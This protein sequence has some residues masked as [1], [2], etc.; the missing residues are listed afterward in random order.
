MPMS[1]LSSKQLNKYGRY[2]GEPTEEQLAHHFYL[3][4][5]DIE[6]INAHR[7]PYS[8]LGFALQLCTLRFLGTFLSEPT[9][10]P[11]NVLAY[12]ARQLKIADLGCINKYLNRP[13]THWEHAEEIKEKLGY[14]DFHN[15]PHY[16]RLV[17]WLYNKVWL[18]DERPSV[19]FDL[20]TSRLIHQKIILPGATVLARLVSRIRNRASEGIYQALIKNLD[21]QQQ[22]ALLSLLHIPD[23]KHHSLLDELRKAPTYVSSVSLNKALQRVKIIKDLAVHDIKTPSVP[24]SR[25][26]KL[27]KLTAGLKA[28][29]IAQMKHS[30]KLAALLCFAQHYEAVALDDAI[31]VFD[32]LVDKYLKEL[33][34]NQKKTTLRRAQD[35]DRAAI[36]LAQACAFLLDQQVADNSIRQTVFK[37]IAKTKLKA[38]TEK[39]TELT[40]EAIDNSAKVISR[41]YRSARKFMSIFL[42]LM[43]FTAL[44]STQPLKDAFELLKTNE[45][46]G[47]KDLDFATAP[48]DFIPDSWK[49][50]VYS[51][52]DKISKPH[53]TICF[54]EQ[55]RLAIRR[56]D[57]FVQ[58]SI[59]WTDPR[60]ELLQGEEWTKIKPTVCKGLDRSENA[61]DQ[62]ALLQKQLDECYHRTEKNLEANSYLKIEQNDKGKDRFLL[63]PLQPLA[64][65]EQLE[66]LKEQIKK[67]MPQVDL[68]SIIM[69]VNRWTNFDKQ[70]LHLTGHEK[71]VSNFDTSLSAVLL[72]EACNIG[73]EPIQRPSNP[74]L[75]KGRLD[76]I[77]RNYI[78]AENLTKANVKLVDYQYHL[79]LAT[80]WGGGEVASADGLRFIVPV[81]AINAKANGKYFKNTKGVTYYNYTSD[82]FTGLNDI[83]IPG[84][85]RDS[86]FLLAGILEQPTDLKPIQIMTDT[87]GY[88]DIVF[89]LFYMLGYQF[90][91]RIADTGST[92]FWRMDRKTDYGQL[93]GIAR[94]KID[95]ELIKT[96]WDEILRLIASLKTGKVQALQIM[97]ILQRGGHP[98]SLGKA[99]QELGRIIKTIHSLTYVDDE[100]YRR[101]IL[102]QLNRGESRHELAR[103][104]FHGKKGEIRKRYVQGQENQLSALGLVTNMVVLWNTKYMQ[105]A[106]EHLQK[107]GMKITPDQIARLSPLIHEHVN[108]LGQYNFDLD[109]SILQGLLRPLRDPDPI[110]EWLGLA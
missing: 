20:A 6:W 47:V 87:A 80:H 4:S 77:K 35:L 14:Q 52:P 103:A 38:A 73:I 26:T 67:L 27:A 93:N 74:V 60:E 9:D 40:T 86:L 51:S 7:R 108:M 81:R 10:V 44:P 88:S 42:D 85:D 78:L 100:N 49:A 57:L 97:Q 110:D 64:E 3:S 39:V 48:Q 31:E 8:K 76:W 21:R 94:N 71:K 37:E 95:M 30:K 72:S 99:I 61:E 98:N 18:N 56:R 91:P 92:R 32:L 96:H 24:L 25:K 63:S 22:T 2:N 53:Y 45:A 36:I 68:P 79:P 1:F 55:I 102:T 11:A 12:V 70:F 33:K 90:S 43:Q 58:P 82:Q 105:L 106:I 34:A 75:S 5:S 84:T 62:L 13:R 109:S 69:E 41:K 17:R 15:H 16:F 19:L 59:K 29:S 104:I 54:L 107:Q 83:V 66:E 50:Y 23:S 65:S 89:G 28:G 46:D 101:S